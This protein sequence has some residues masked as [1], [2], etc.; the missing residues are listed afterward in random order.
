VMAGQDEKSTIKNTAG[1]ISDAVVAK[2][3]TKTQ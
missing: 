1:Q 3:H 2:L